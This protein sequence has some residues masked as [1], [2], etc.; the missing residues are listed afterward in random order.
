[1]TVGREMGRA[2]SLRD[3][4]HKREITVFSSAV[5]PQKIENA[6]QYI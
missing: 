3:Q 2:Y 1:M 6:M 5:P 4:V